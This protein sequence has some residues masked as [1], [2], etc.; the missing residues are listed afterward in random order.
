MIIIIVSVF[1]KKR[2]A[3]YA[4]FVLQLLNPVGQCL[5]IGSFDGFFPSL[6]VSLVFCGVFR[7]LLMLKKNGIDAWTTIMSSDEDFEY[8]WQELHEDESDDEEE[9]VE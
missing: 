2:W 6:F 8:L 7:L 4:F 3:V 9:P 1:R 5:L